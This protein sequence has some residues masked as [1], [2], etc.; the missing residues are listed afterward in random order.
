MDNEETF[1][2]EEREYLNP[3]T[4][5]NEQLGFI[6]TLRDV[7]ARNNQQIAQETQA[8]GTQ[9]PSNLGGLTGAQGM[10]E[11]RYQTPQVAATVADLKAQAQQTALNTALS[12]QQNMWKNRYN[13][14]QRALTR[15]QHKYNTKPSSSSNSNSN[16]SFDQGVNNIGLDEGTISNID[17]NTGKINAV[18]GGLAGTTAVAG[19]GYTDYYNENGEVVR[20]YDDGRIETISQGKST[21]LGSSKTSVSD[22]IKKLE[23]S[24]KTVLNK[25]ITVD[26][27]G[28]VVLNW[29]DENGDTGS[30]VVQVTLLG[31]GIGS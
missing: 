12:N 1:T 8:L 11:A 20:H 13:Q 25:N 22:T 7:Q 15:A 31:R 10:W 21:S 26:E 6:D 19:E 4:S 2:F 29:R 9:V 24:G 18:V 27:G 17:P 5:R 14:A 28:R 30:E 16:N 3:A 23:S